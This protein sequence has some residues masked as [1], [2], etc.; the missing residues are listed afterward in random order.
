MISGGLILNIVLQ[1][2]IGGL[3]AYVLW[4][5]LSKI[6]LP[7]PINKVALVLLVILIAIWLINLLLT[8]GG[9]PIVHWG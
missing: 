2:V 1:L 7:E 5:A 9:H 6:A 3:V 8:L 4:W